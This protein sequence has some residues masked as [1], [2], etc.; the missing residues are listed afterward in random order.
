MYRA[1]RVCVFVDDCFW[2]GSPKCYRRPGANRKFWDA[3]WGRNY[4]REVEVTRELRRKGWNVLQ[5][6]EQDLKKR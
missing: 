3:K 2:K 4:A 6:R 5:I 1:K